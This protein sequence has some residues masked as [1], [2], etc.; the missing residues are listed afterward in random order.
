MLAR[1]GL[2][3]VQRPAFQACANAARLSSLTLLRRISTVKT[4]H[5]EAQ[6]ILIAQRKN[7][8]GSPHLTIYQPQITWIMS[9]FHRI[10]GVFMAGGFYLLTCTYGATSI[11][12]LPFDSSVLVGAFASLPV[13]LKVG[14]K[15]ICA[16]PFVYHVGNGLRHLVWDFGKALTNDGV[17]KTGYAVLGATAIIGSYLAFLW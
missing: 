12:G 2:A 16:Y 10:T 14:I 8:P 17:Y 9:S 13:V 7:R 3:S 11:L 4:T 6:E 15:A 5:D 1:V